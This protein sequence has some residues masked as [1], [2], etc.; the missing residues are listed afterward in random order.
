MSCELFPAKSFYA[1]LLLIVCGVSGADE[2]KI[3]EIRVYEAL[4]NLT[5]GKIFFSAIE[6]EALDQIRT[7]KAPSTAT[8]K[9]RP[10]KIDKGAAGY[11]TSSTGMSKVYDGADFVTTTDRKSPAFPSA[12]RIVRKRSER[13]AEKKADAD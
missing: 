2:N 10:G 13:S 1:L 5:V 9:S 7:G 6:R 4:P 12:V 3:D 11:I 8:I